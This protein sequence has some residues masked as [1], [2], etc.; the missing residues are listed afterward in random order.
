MILPCCCEKSDLI[1]DNFAEGTCSSK[2]WSGHGIICVVCRLW[3][4]RSRVKISVGERDCS[5]LQIVQN[6][7]WAHLASYS[8]DRGVS[9]QGT[10]SWSMMLTTHFH[11]APILGISGDKQLLSTYLW[12]RNGLIFTF[13][14]EAVLHFVSMMLP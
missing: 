10:C 14:Y 4:E 8:I 2:Y 6:G 3:A 5:L 13:R 7:S 9:S 11:L 12:R 1:L